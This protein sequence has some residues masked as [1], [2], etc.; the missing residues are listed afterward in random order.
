MQSKNNNNVVIDQTGNICLSSLFTDLAN[1]L[2]STNHKRIGV[3]YIILGGLAGVVG[4]ALSILIRLQLMHASTDTFLG[5]N[6][7]YYTAITAHG[8]IM[9]FF[10]VM[11][12]LFGGFGNFFLPSLIGASDMAFPRLNNISLWLTA[13]AFIMLL[14]SAAIETG[15]GTGWTLYPPLSSSLGHP[16]AGI[17]YGIFGMHLAG[18]GS[19]AGSINFIVTV[20]NMRSDNMTMKRLPLFPW[21]LYVTS[22]LLVLSLP[23][24]AAA[25]TM[26]LTDRILNTAFFDATAGGD[27]VLYQHLFWFFGHPE[28][29]ILILPA[30]GVISHAIQAVTNR[31][32]FGRTSMIIAIISIGI[33][34]FIVWAHHMYTVG[35]DIDTRAYFSAATMVIA[36][37]TG[38][39]VFNWIASLFAGRLNTSAVATY[40]ILAFI[41]LFTVGG[42]T[43]I[44]LSNASLDVVLHDTYYVVAH[45]H[46][47]LSMGAVFAI[48]CGFYMWLD[49]TF[50]VSY[51]VSLA[52]AHFW[53]MTLGVN[54]TFFPMHF[55]GLQ[56]M[57]RRIP[58]YPW[59]FES[60]NQLASVGSLLSLI[61]M[62]V[63]L[64]NMIVSF[65]E[66]INSRSVLKTINSS[67]YNPD[68]LVLLFN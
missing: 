59:M 35:M 16:H 63:F 19:L 44:I 60:F 13:A 42:L 31:P 30:F 55:L 24:F 62:I 61:A 23:V 21:T 25:I 40:F 49:K 58:E 1:W 66:V 26:L 2:F 56:G 14:T 39:K 12:I 9:I 52:K 41:L 67:R 46:Y 36:V 17:E 38:I 18:A 7:A 22:Y 3:M 54:L 5:N 4:T 65:S 33:L 34:G 48:F 10:M 6:A 8:L 37:P 53:L 50:G 11:P 20:N 51:S 47:V 68:N 43:G 32:I 29:Y 15:V 57:P 28:V 64:I 27:P 45:F